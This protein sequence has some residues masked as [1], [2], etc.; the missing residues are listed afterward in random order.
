MCHLFAHSPE[1]PLGWVRAGAPPWRCLVLATQSPC[2]ATSQQLQPVSPWGGATSVSTWASAL[3]HPSCLLGR[4]SSVQGREGS[5]SPPGGA[6]S[7]P[8][9]REVPRAGRSTSRVFTHE[10]TTLFASSPLHFPDS[11]SFSSASAAIRVSLS[12]SLLPFVHQFSDWLR[13]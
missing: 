10:Q 13:R 7:L 6:L 5:Q 9:T 3:S 1:A 4:W 2:R 11:P 12:G 8:R